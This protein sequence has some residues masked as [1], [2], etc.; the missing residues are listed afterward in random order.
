MACRCSTTCSTR[1]RRPPRPHPGGSA[2]R[3]TVRSGSRP[4]I[5]WG[6]K[7]GTAAGGMPHRPRRRVDGAPKKI[8]L[9]SYRVQEHDGGL[10]T[11]KNLPP[12]LAKG[13]TT[14]FDPGDAAVRLLDLQRR[15][16]RRRRLHLRSRPWWRS[17]PAARQAALQG[18]DLSQP[19]QGL[20]QDHPPQLPDR[21]G[22]LDQR[23]FPGRRLPGGQRDLDP[24]T[25]VLNT[26]GNPGEAPNDADW[27]R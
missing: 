8:E 2:R 25:P 13:S 9:W 12:P 11:N 27:L 22:V 19:R 20:G 14:E 7:P 15:P 16:E 17:Q 6:S 21:L 3:A 5:A 1:S 4:I 18:D 24:S 23:R 26:S 10:A